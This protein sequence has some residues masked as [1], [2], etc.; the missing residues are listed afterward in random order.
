MKTVIRCALTEEWEK[1][2]N[3]YVREGFLADAAHVR[4][5]GPFEFSQIGKERM[6]WFAESNGEVIGAVQ[7]VF[8]HAE[9]DLANGFDSAF[10][11]HLRVAYSH[12]GRGIAAAMFEALLVEAK[13]RNLKTITLEV[14][15]RNKL[16]YSVYSHWGFAHLRA[17]KEEFQIVMRKQL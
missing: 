3:L 9:E 12:H 15:L 7:L 13:K 10:V 5:D 6:I 2:T 14:D 17:G 16:A 4:R 8:R 11:H 1:L